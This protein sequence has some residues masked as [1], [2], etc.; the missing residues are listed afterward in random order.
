MNGTAGYDKRSYLKETMAIS[1]S[2]DTRTKKSSA[3]TIVEIS[4]F[5]RKVDENCA[6]LGCNFQ[7]Y[8]RLINNI[9]NL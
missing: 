9:L 8:A 1:T 3:K 2:T 6:L 5:R 4:G 7:N